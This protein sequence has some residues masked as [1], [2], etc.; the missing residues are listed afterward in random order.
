MARWLYFNSECNMWK[1]VMVT[2]PS[3]FPFYRNSYRA[4]CTLIKALSQDGA[5]C[6]IEEAE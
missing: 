4:A 3:T 6:W 5:T 2:N 1:V